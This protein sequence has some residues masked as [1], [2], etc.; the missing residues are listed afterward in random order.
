MWIKRYP[1]QSDSL[2][3]WLRVSADGRVTT[4]VSLPKDLE[5]LDL[6]SDRVAVLRRDEF[7]TEQIVVR[8]LR[9]SG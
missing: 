4:R 1:L 6:R 8:G 2:Q 5:V 3:H 7:E 9:P